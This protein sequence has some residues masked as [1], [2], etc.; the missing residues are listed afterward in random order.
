MM[1]WYGH[2]WNFGTWFFTALLCVVLIG[3]IIWIVSRLSPSM[4]RTM[5]GGTE[6]AEDILDKR[7][8][9]GE[10]DEATYTSHRDALTAARAP[11]PGTP[12]PSDISTS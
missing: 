3:L 6:S 12:R 5:T 8:A 9:R 4:N 10:I 1:G 7:F 2:G 11:R